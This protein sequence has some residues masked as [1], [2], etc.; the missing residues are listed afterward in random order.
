MFGSTEWLK[1]LAPGNE[2]EVI[3]GGLGKRLTALRA[4]LWQ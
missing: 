3:G 1:T 4:W 2:V